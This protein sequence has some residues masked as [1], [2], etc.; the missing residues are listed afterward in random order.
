MQLA[1]LTGM[2]TVIFGEAI[3]YLG[4]SYGDAVLSRWPLVDS[5]VFLLPAAPNHEKRVAVAVVV[6]EPETGRRIRFVGT[7]LD[8]TSNP[9]DRIAQA[10]ALNARLL[11]ADMP[12]LLVGDLNAEPDSQPM[13]VLFDAGWQPADSSHLPTFPSKDATKKIDWFLRAPGFADG[14]GKVEVLDEPIASDH[15]PIVTTW[16]VVDNAASA[17]RIP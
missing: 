3:P 15:C 17:A 14:F 2:N 16:I 9:S 1:A 5:D 10:Q 6:E 11:P 8:H 12:T 4:G 13:K 7:H